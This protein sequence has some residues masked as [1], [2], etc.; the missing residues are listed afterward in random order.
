MASTLQRAAGAVTAFATG[1]SRHRY[2]PLPLPGQEDLDDIPIE[3]RRK[4]HPRRST[5]RRD[6]ILLPLSVLLILALGYW[7][8]T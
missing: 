3:R 7:V 1:R 6:V 5:F 2:Q 4:I 8:T